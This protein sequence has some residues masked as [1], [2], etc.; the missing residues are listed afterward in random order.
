M[1]QIRTVLLILLI[2]LAWPAQADWF[3]ADKDDGG[4]GTLANRAPAGSQAF[5][6]V[7][8]E[9]PATRDKLLDLL[10]SFKQSKPKATEKMERRFGMSLEEWTELFGGRAMVALVPSGSRRHLIHRK[11]PQFALA[12]S[13]RPAFHPWFKEHLL[14]RMGRDE[15]R[16]EFTECAPS[17]I[18]SSDSASVKKWL[19]FASG[20][21]AYASMVE[22]GSRQRRE[23]RRPFPLL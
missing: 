20:G 17:T 13:L 14:P 11:P 10:G 2:S 3:S 4:T 21:E 9:N 6:S 15:G 18:V 12:L 5:L 16:A 23:P 22:G 1:T 19:Y 8:L 7:N